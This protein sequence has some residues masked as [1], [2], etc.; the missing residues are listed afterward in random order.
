MTNYSAFHGQSENKS[1]RC[2]PF[3]SK[4]IL[5]YENKPSRADLFVFVEL[6]SPVKPGMTC[7]T[8]MTMLFPVYK[9]IYLGI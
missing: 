8:G 1:G 7:G 6:R 3:K 5:S 4:E 9:D 2:A